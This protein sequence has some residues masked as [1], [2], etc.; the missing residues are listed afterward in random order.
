MT[1]KNLDK[2]IV[3]LIPSAT[4]IVCA[5]GARDRLVGVSHECDYPL[6]VEVLPDCC[7]PK[8]DPKGLSIDVDNRVKQ[9]VEEGLSVYRVLADRLKDLGPS[10][11]VTQAQ[12]E[13]CGVSEQ[14]LVKVLSTWL[15]DE[16]PV[17]VSLNPNN[18]KAVWADIQNVAN[19]LDTPRAGEDLIRALTTR[20]REIAMACHGQPAKK[21]FCMEWMDPLMAGGNWIPELVDLVGASSILAKA[22]EHSPWITFED[23][24]QEDPDIIAIMPCGYDLEQVKENLPG[25]VARPEWQALRAVQD[26]QVYLCDGN[27]FF[28]RPGPRLVESVEILGEILHPQRIQ[29]GHKGRSYIQLGED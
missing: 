7:E 25:L 11:V 2:S 18:M 10:V 21:I 6:G 28:N 1:S 13:V 14:E 19:A 23:V 27:Q 8:F 3:T 12:C 9:I 17:V 24:A 29:L 5:L 4:E 26:G 20:M 22:G 16:R 15:E